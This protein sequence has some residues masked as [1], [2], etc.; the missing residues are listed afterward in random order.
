MKLV[1]PMAGR[2]ERFKQA[3]YATPKP[4]IEIAPGLPMFVKAA[5]SF[6]LEEMQEIV[7]VVLREHCA[8]YGIDREIQ[9]HFAGLPVRLVILDEVTS[10]QAETVAV[11][12]DRTQADDHLMVFNADSAF[13]DDLRPWI[14]T[15]A[16]NY[17]GAL[18]VF[19]DTDARWSFARVNAS[20]D[21][22][23]TTEKKPISDLASTGLYYFRSW[24]EYL[25]HYAALEVAQGEKYI[26]PL[27]NRFLEQGL[28]VGIIPCRRY[29]CFGTPQ[30]YQ[31][32]LAGKFFTY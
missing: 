30:D 23:E 19:R 29:L 6:P 9:R 32:C 21:V 27:Y 2:G 28:R 26:A 20:G 31:S 15:Q 14:K 7:F 8:A 13:E 1:I 4:L 22:V 18:Q 3:G 5:R 12:L 24:R 10:G 25:E 17:A 16:G 11:A